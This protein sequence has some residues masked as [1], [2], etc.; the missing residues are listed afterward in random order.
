MA[1]ESANLFSGLN[2]PP[3]GEAFEDIVRLGPVRIERIASSATP[4]PVVY[5]QPWDEWVLLVQGTARLWLDG[6]EL[7]M[8]PGDHVLIPA[9]TVHRVLETSLQPHCL[10]LA[11]HV[12]RAAVR[13][14]G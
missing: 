3:I 13:P 4:E 7:T 6:A 8:G 9:H 2:A 12:E 10:W 5:D 1:C 11:V 14:P